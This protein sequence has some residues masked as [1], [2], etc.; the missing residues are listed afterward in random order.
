MT[1]DFEKMALSEL[2][3]LVPQSPDHVDVSGA[4]RSAY[5]AGMD[6]AVA[7]N[8]ERAAG[9][10]TFAQL[11]LGDAAVAIRSEAASVGGGK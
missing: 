7:I 2:P 11:A 1:P 8:L 9:L 5:V 6:R 10:N 3:H 4:L